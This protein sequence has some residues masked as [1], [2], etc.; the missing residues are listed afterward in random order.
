MLIGYS[1]L[2]VF[3]F[4]FQKVHTYFSHSQD[5]DF[6]IKVEN[7]TLVYPTY[8]HGLLTDSNFIASWPEHILSF[9][10]FY[11]IIPD[12]IE[13]CCYGWYDE[14]TKS[15]AGMMKHVILGSY[16]L[17]ALLKLRIKEKIFRFLK[18]KQMWHLE[19]LVWILIVVELLLVWK[20]GF[21]LQIFFQ[22]IQECNLQFGT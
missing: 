7:N 19:D 18:I 21:S 11:D 22:S 4:F 5:Y 10:E 15:W 12:F 8:R 2:W 14:D 17:I 20:L 16:Y 9:I 1:I 6:Y 13:A 3:I